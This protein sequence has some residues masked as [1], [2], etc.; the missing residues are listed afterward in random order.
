MDLQLQVTHG[1]LLPPI[2]VDPKVCEFDKTFSLITLHSG[3]ITVGRSSG[4]TLHAPNVLCGKVS[5][6]H[7]VLRKRTFGSWDV[8]DVGSS[9]G[10]WITRGSQKLDVR[11]GPVK[12]ERADRI[13]F[14]KPNKEESLE[15][16]IL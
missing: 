13:V 7:A 1:Q 5:R 16:L 4:S 6:A 11:N 9:Y 2:D 14:G 3:E 12:I 10:T 8:E 15:V